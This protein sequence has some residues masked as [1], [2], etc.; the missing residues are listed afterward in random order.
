MR[1][2]GYYEGQFINGEMDGTGIR[3]WGFN[4][5]FYEGQF[6]KGEMNGLGIMKYGNG[7]IYE[8]PWVDNKREGMFCLCQQIKKKLLSA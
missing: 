8:G 4:G 2:G 7:S 5:N 3:F 1:D 6:R